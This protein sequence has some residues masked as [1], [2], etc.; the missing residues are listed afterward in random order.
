MEEKIL[1]ID[2][3]SLIYYEAYKEKV[4]WAISGI[5]ER[6]KRIMEEN[7]TTK[8]ILFLTEGKCFRYAE[9]KSKDYKANRTSN[10]PTWFRTIRSYLKEK[11]NAMSINGLEAD[12]CVAYFATKIPNSRICSPDKDVLLQCP[13]EHFNYQLLPVKDSDGNTIGG[14]SKGIVTTSIED[15]QK[16][17]YTQMLMGDSTDGISG[18]E[19]VGPKTA[20][21][22]LKDFDKDSPKGTIE[23]LILSKYIEKYDQVDGLSR[24]AETFKLVYL[25][26]TDEDMLR[27]IKDIP[28][29][30]DISEYIVETEDTVDD[31]VT[32]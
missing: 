22:W 3:D 15:A 26:K 17:L 9:A 27:E 21:K 2:A 20:E 29:I 24:F 16:F 1:L 6:I 25:L 5:D 8:Y 32:W 11:Y 28:N 13:G 30:P 4:E 14:E 18:I 23:Q 7:N 19:K 10:K 12:D 31:T